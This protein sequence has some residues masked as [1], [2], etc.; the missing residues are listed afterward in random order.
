[1]HEIEDHGERLK[2]I[3]ELIK[4]LLYRPI[5]DLRDVYQQML[6]VLEHNRKVYKELTRTPNYDDTEFHD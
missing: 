2:K 4:S 5:E 3:L 6:P 1:M